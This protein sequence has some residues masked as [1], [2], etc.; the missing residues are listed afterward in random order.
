MWR[1]PEPTRRCQTMGHRAVLPV[2]LSQVQRAGPPSYSLIGK[3]EVL[4]EKIDEDARA[5]S[6][7]HRAR[8][9]AQCGPM[10]SSSMRLRDPP[11]RSCFLKLEAS[12]DD[13]VR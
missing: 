3:R 13:E 11:N 8:S 9:S 2:V 5:R 4:R 10:T 12:A 1:R 6:A 7:G